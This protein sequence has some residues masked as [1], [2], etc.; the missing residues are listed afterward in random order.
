MISRKIGK[1]ERRGNAS[2]G[3]ICIGSIRKYVRER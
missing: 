1:N 3:Y 2:E